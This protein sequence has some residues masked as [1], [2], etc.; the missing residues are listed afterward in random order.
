MHGKTFA[1]LDIGRPEMQVQ[2]VAAPAPAA[3]V[4]T[5][6]AAPVATTA[7]FVEFSLQSTM[8]EAA[9]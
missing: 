2:A 6:P 1:S 8:Q 5:A 4:A 9:K 3:T 7:P